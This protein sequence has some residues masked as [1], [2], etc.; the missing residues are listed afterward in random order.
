MKEISMTQESNEFDIETYKHKFESSL[1]AFKGDLSGLRT[2]RANV[3]MLDPIQVESYGAMVPLNTVA[4][5]SAPEPRLLTVTVWDKAMVTVVSKAIIH[6]GLGLNPQPDGLLIRLPIPELNEERRKEI[7]KVA[8]KYAESSRV[9]IR[10]IRRDG[11][12]TLKKLEKSKAISE[13]EMHRQLDALQKEVDAAIAQVDQ[14][15][16]EKEKEIMSV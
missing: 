4:N 6:S 10:N 9:V 2:G 15:L 11:N 3:S 5:I 12:D 8:A 1:K 7:S 13:D 14:L 16:S